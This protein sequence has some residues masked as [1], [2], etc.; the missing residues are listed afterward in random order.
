[1]SHQKQRRDRTCRDP[2]LETLAEQYVRQSSGISPACLLDGRTSKDSTASVKY[3]SASEVTRF[4]GCS[5]EWG[6]IHRAELRKGRC[7]SSAVSCQHDR[8]PPA[9][10]GC[11]TCVSLNFRIMEFIKMQSCV[12]ARPLNGTWGC[13]LATGSAPITGPANPQSQALATQ[14]I[15]S[16]FRLLRQTKWRG[17]ACP[18]NQL[19]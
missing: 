11:D 12:R 16:L 14:I 6:I 5:H 2:R 7:D 10:S 13:K 18:T 15:L 9:V 19:E 3:L 4:S 8:T 1:M 17:A